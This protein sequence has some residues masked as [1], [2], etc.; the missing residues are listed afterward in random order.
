MEKEKAT[1]F[2]KQIDGISYIV[3][4]HFCSNTKEKLVDKCKKLLKTEILSEK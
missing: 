3:T 2:E 4:L 1:T